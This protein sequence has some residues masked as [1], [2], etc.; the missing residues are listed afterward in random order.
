LEVIGFYPYSYYEL[1][2]NKR[3]YA[4]LSTDCLPKIYNIERMD[5]F[6]SLR[7]FTQVVKSGGFAA[8]ARE[9]GLSRSAVNKLV[10]S[11]ENRLGVQLLHRSTR[12]VTPTATGLA[13][14]AQCVEILATLEEAERSV[15]QLHEEPKGRLRINAPMSF[16]TMH[17]APV[18]ADFLAQ[19]PDLQVQLTL[20]DR[21]ID[22]IEE[23]FDVTVRIAKPQAS[24]SLVVH[25]LIPAQRVL[26]AAP[27]YL[28]SRGVP[29]QPDELRH[30]SCLHYGQLA[31]E[32]RWTFSRDGEDRTIPVTGVLCSNNGEVLRAAAVRGLGITLLPTFFVEEDF[33]QGTL[34][35]VLPDYRLPELLVS[36]IYPVNRHLSTK[37]RLL[38]KFLQ[39]RFH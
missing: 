12:V 3:Q 33:R 14:H 28:K 15:T 31:A 39:D 34:Q 29:A 10:I 36:A 23:G 6:E 21:F 19:Y 24:A 1:D 13:F 30:H 35:V 8:A 22:P 27:S 11:L 4:I 7:A 37:I 26:C 20:S 25:P 16:G 5:R 38:V 18:I 32:D 9:M 17:L 2:L